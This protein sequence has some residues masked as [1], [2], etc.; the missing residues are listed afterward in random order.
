[1]LRAVLSLRTAAREGFRSS[2]FRRDPDFPP[3]ALG[4]LVN[5]RVVR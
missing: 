5:V 2:E 1:M 4:F 3:L